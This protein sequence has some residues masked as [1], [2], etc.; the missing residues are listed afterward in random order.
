MDMWRERGRYARERVRQNAMRVARALIADERSTSASGTCNVST[1]SRCY[2][3]V[4]GTHTRVRLYGAV[5]TF[6]WSK[7]GDLGGGYYF[8]PQFLLAAA[9]AGFAPSLRLGCC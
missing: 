2:A 7:M 4:V 5:N 3:C 6:R 1:T 8:V 9:S